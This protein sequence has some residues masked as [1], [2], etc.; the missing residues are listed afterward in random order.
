MVGSVLYQEMLV[1]TRR[2]KWHWLRWIYAGW[3]VLLTGFGLLFYTAFANQGRGMSLDFVQLA[4][5]CRWELDFLS[6]QHFLILTLIT[7]VLAAG[8]ITDEKSRGTLQYLFAADLLSWEILVGK[9]IGRVYQAIMFASI[10]FPIICFIG[11]FAG[12]DFLSLLCFIAATVVLL[13]SLGSMSLMAS[14]WCRHTRD[15]VLTLYAILGTIYL[16]LNFLP[17]YLGSFNIVPSWI[18]DFLSSINPLFPM[19]K[20]WVFEIWEVRFQQLIYFSVVWGG[21]GLLCLI[22]S[23]LCLR[24]KYIRQL[25][26]AGRSKKRWWKLGRRPAMGDS[27]L[28]WKERYVEGIAPLAVLR[29]LPTWLGVALVSVLTIT[30]CLVIFAF[31]LPVSYPPSRVWAELMQADGK[32]FSTALG[33]IHGKCGPAFYAQGWVVMLLTGLI[34]GIRCSGA[35]TGEREKSTWEALL[36]TPLDNHQL[37][38]GKLWGIAGASVPYLLAYAIPALI[39]SG[40]VGLDSFFWTLLWFGVIILAVFYVGAAGLW[41]SVRSKSSW[42]SLINTL[43]FTYLGGFVLGCLLSVAAS[44]LMI[45]V[46]MI[47]AIIESMLDSYGISNN[48]GGART[49]F[50]S[51]GTAWNISICIVTAIAFAVLSWLL[52]RSAEYRVGILERIKHWK[53]E[54]RRPFRRQR[55]RRPPPDYYYD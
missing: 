41:C 17:D 37:I 13:F 46:L 20:T 8:A 15:A 36:L 24:W 1:S 54:P 12:L 48:V 3:L 42:R 11:I 34:V 47:M 2:S 14:V 26:N 23:T 22:L 32:A 4:G 7:P 51:M 30:A 55:R 27:P 10:G 9:L 33:H 39:L 16:L 45:F 21:A 53:N 35:V 49:T 43:A 18:V 6:W 29:A 5:F 44:I 40:L 19:G 52:V 25:E 28:T 38:R 31:Y 50:A